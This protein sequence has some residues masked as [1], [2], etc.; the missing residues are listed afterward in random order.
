MKQGRTKKFK[1]RR[2]SNPSNPKPKSKIRKIS[3]PRN[4]LNFGQTHSEPKRG[5]STKRSW[6]KP[7]ERPKTK[8]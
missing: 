5:E 2:K 1:A 6:Q 4:K 7:E 3:E 8:K